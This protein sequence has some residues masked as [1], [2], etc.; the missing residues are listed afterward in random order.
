MLTGAGLG[1]R[2]ARR[3]PAWC[4]RTGLEFLHR[5]L[6]APGWS[7]RGRVERT[8][9]KVMFAGRVLQHWLAGPPIGNGG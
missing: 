3:A 1:I 9:V 4:R 5:A 7:I 6:T 8:A 2:Y